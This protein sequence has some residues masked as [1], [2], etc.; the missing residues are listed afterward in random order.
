MN[1]KKVIWGFILSSI[2]ISN[3]NALSLV[4][5][6]LIDKIIDKETSTLWQDFK[7][8]SFESC[9][10]VY[11]VMKKYINES[12]RP[13]P[14]Y[15]GFGQ[16]DMLE[17][18]LEADMAVPESSSKIAVG[19]ENFS[20]TNTQVSWVDE[21]EI[22]KTDWKYVYYYNNSKQAVYILEKTGEEIKVVKKIKIPKNLSRV[23][24]YLNDN[25]LVILADWY[26]ENASSKW[27][28]FNRSSKTY[29][30]VYDITDKEN[31]KLDRINVTDWH[32][33]KSR[34]IWDTLYVLSEND[35]FSQY[36]SLGDPEAIF[37]S[38]SFIPKQID[39]SRTSNKTEQNLRIKDT[40]YPYNIKS[41]KAADCSNISYVVPDDNTPDEYSF[42]PS[43]T[44]ITA[45]N[46]NSP[47][48]KPTN[49]VVMWDIREI[50]MSLDNLYVTS[51]I[52]TKNNFS[53]PR[54]TF[55]IMPWYPR[56]EN[57][58]IH[59]MA[60]N[61]WDIEYKTSNI[62]PWL[63]LTQYAMDEHNWNFR[64]TTQI[65]W[66]ERSTNLF[67]L[68]ENLKEKGKLENIAPW[69][70][71]KSSRFMGEKL[72]LVTFE[73]IDPFF[74]VDLQDDSNPKILW[75]LKI[76]G[77]STYLH[78]Y[79]ENHVIGLGYDT[80]ENEYGWVYNNWI[81]IDLYDVSDFNNPT[82]KHTL[83]VWESGSYSEALNNPRMFVWDYDRKTLLIP[84]K[85]QTNEEWERY[86]AKTYFNWVVSFL[87][88]KDAW[89]KE[90]WR[91]THISTD[92]IEEKRNKE[93]EEYTKKLD[94]QNTCRKLLNG[95]T[96][97]EKKY[98]YV[99]NYC[100]ADSTIDQYVAAKSWEFRD[101]AINRVIYIWESIIALSN[102]KATNNNFDSL[103]ETD[104]ITFE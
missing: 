97:C 87:V 24:M 3:S 2:F 81:K 62:V 86:K 26:S 37:N 65:Y 92:W 16:V 95:E 68:D 56:G 101:N 89:I 50:Y 21:S 33:S 13:Y 10:A 66:S 82:Q 102:A 55:C 53:C 61:K 96:Y 52:Y 74:V 43:Y 23:Q 79:D 91:I 83:T 93:C 27:Y 8:K 64:I 67:I 28:Y 44:T 1:L 22:V 99:P 39:I 51:H 59:K 94:N 49:K 30:I 25:K 100:Y 36:Y 20:E 84:A 54:D 60:I 75:E 38:D 7:M 70:D 71:F 72:Y 85:I 80:A 9:D 31:L 15:R 104:S 48:E 19:S 63:P 45:I 42:N 40:I 58:V 77:Y 14:Y 35:F 4:D 6:Q 98:V 76:P 34:R 103:S 90:K 17:S 73:Q 12:Q 88:D 11:D 47:S 78:P 5:D 41:W 18:T 29:S 57:T 46:L 69:E 32:L